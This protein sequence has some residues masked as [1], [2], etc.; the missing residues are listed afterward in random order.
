MSTLVFDIGGTNMRIGCGEGDALAETAKFPT[1]PTPEAG[2]EALKAFLKEE[3]LSPRIIVGGFAGVVE[4]GRIVRSRN[5]PQWSGYDLASALTD[6]IGAPA[7]VYNDAELAGVGE[8]RAG[9]GK[10]YATVAYMTFG[11][12]VGGTLVVNG[13]PLSHAHGL[14]PGKQLLEGQRT[15]EDLVGGAALETEFGAPPFK[16]PRSVFDERTP[17]LARGIY[18]AICDWSPDIFV[19]NG[20]LLNDETAF[21]LADI[22]AELSRIAEPGLVPPLVRAALGDSSGLTGALLLAEEG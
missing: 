9:A 15:L 18:N 6:A 1:P 12:G 4:N 13:S 3:T 19:V 17:A 2:V 21:R 5:L 10:G 16:L 11:T 8:A 14:E 7:R 22:T 20:S